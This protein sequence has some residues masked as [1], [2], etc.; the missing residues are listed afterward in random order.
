MLDKGP[1]FSTR[2]VPD[3]ALIPLRLA[4]AQARALARGYVI[5]GTNVGYMAAHQMGRNQ[6]VRKFLG[7]SKADK[8]E[9]NAIFRSGLSPSKATAK[10]IYGAVGDYMLLS[11]DQRFEAEIDPSGNPWAPNQPGILAK[12][13]AAGRILKVLQDTGRGRASIN[14]KVIA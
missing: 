4:S 10:G 14:K 6:K 11:T 12:K 13:R 3:R 9:I 2:Y 1:V 7:I 8:R 5:I